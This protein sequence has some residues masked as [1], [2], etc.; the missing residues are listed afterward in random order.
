[1]TVTL[2]N[3]G[4]KKQ[5]YR[6]VDG[7]SLSNEDQQKLRIVERRVFDAS[8]E[9]ILKEA[10]DKKWSGSLDQNRRADT[11]VATKIRTSFRVFEN[12]TSSSKESYFYFK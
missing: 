8:R 7:E 9:D 2:G 10:T 3:K 4:F 12:S 6:L 11:I 5:F 1:M